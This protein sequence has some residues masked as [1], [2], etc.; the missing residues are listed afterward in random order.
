MKAIVLSRRDF[1]EFD[2]IV[3]LY[4]HEQGK[5]ELLARGVKK[6]TSKNAAALLPFSFV[7]AEWVRG[8]EI[9][10]LTTAQPI[11][12]F[13]RI[14]QNLSASLLAGYAVEIV[15][16]LVGSGE[17]D[18]KLFS[19]LFGWLKYLDATPSASSIVLT[20][21]IWR[22]LGELGFMPELNACVSCGE[23]RVDYSWFDL[24]KG[25]V[26]CVVCVTK[27]FSEHRQRL[28]GKELAVLRSLVLDPWKIFFG[29]LCTKPERL[30]QNILAFN[31]VTFHAGKMACDWRRVDNFIDG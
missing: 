15:H 29:L 4:T 11:D 6:I 26:L 16:Q 7:E 23:R 18:E 2:Q 21:F 25:G 24:E 19:L 30:R 12:F 31:F 22:A 28:S 13:S 1:R 14:R 17:R 20:A 8:Q 3:S 5:V 9:N 10:H 27:A